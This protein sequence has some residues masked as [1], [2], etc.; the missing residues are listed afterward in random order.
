MKCESSH[1]VTSSQRPNRL[2]SFIPPDHVRILFALSPVT[3][4]GCEFHSPF[5]LQ[6]SIKAILRDHYFPVPMVVDYKTDATRAVILDFMRMA[7]L[8]SCVEEQK[9]LDLVQGTSTVIH[10]AFV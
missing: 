1:T 7:G 5:S 9:L 2:F 6:A 10:L 8:F 3:L 4:Y